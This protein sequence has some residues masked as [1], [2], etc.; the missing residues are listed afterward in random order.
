MQASPSTSF[1][2]CGNIM[3]V[4]H[5]LSSFSAKCSNAVLSIFPLLTNNFLPHDLH[6]AGTFNFFLHTELLQMGYILMLPFKTVGEH[7][8][9]DW[10]LH[11]NIKRIVIG[12][13]CCEYIT[14]CVNI[15]LYGFIS[16]LVPVCRVC[17]INSEY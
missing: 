14:G 5:S 10:I 8:I 12:A 1:N 7:K 13:I 16:L 4:S 17:D 2:C 9:L 6:E 3:T 15:Y 11:D